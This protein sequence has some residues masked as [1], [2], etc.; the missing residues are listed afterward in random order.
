MLIITIN[1]NKQDVKSIFYCAR[2]KKL[3]SCSTDGILALTDLETM[4]SESLMEGKAF[5]AAIETEN[6]IITAS[7]DGLVM[8]FGFDDTVEQ[9]S[10]KCASRPSALYYY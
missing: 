6:G 4:Q 1:N 2:L 3:V 8:Y 5:C 7:V 9:L 10:V